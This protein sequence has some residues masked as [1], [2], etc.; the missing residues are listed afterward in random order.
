VENEKTLIKGK[1]C[2]WDEVEELHTH[3]CRCCCC[4]WSLQ[5]NAIV[6]HSSFWSELALQ[7]ILRSNITPID[8][9]TSWNPNAKWQFIEH[10]EVH[11][12][13]K[14][15]EAETKSYHCMIIITSLGPES[16]SLTCGFYSGERTMVDHV[17]CRLSQPQMC[18]VFLHHV[19]ASFIP[20]TRFVNDMW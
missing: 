9:K 16:G 3:D 6:K 10:C 7:H 18:A 20:F 15:K 12:L 5:N 4:L 1:T 13:V 8:Q 14:Y 17:L 19:H 11:L 2:R